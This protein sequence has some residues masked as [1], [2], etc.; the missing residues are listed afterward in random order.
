MP[1]KILYESAIHQ[2]L[3]SAKRLR[4]RL[5]SNF[6]IYADRLASW[7]ARLNFAY[8]RSGALDISWNKPKFG[9]HTL[10]LKGAK[11]YTRGDTV[12]HTQRQA[13]AGM[14]FSDDQ[15]MNSNQTF[16]DAELRA[17]LNSS[18]LFNSSELDLIFGEKCISQYPIHDRK[19]AEES[20][21]NDWAAS[22]DI[23]QI[24]V[25]QRNEACTAPEMRYIRSVLADLKGRDVLDVG[26]GLGEA[27][28]YFALEGASVTA[29]DISSGMCD[30]VRCLADANSVTI[31]T[32]VSAIEDLG[33][34]T[35]DCFDIIY[36]GNT[37][38]HADIGA[39]LANV[40]P[41]L[42]S[43]GIFV[44]WDPI[45]YNPLIQIYRRLASGVRTVD[46]HPLTVTDIKLIKK[47]FEQIEIKFFW[48]FTQAIFVY[49]F[50]LQFRHPGKERFWKKVIDEAEQW[51]TLYHLL[52]KV[53]NF[54]LRW[55]PFL[56]WLCWNVV[57]IAH[58]PRAIKSEY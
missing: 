52:E 55:F 49:M 50:V 38:H 26:C 42:K 3:W 46:E 25:R 31:K 53:D 22:E 19:R 24:N 56:G 21:H 28:V 45:L 41:H 37:L 30:A 23:S 1:K 11:F 2:F 35:K 7:I 29:T 27:S 9:T 51:S 10:I 39:M 32:H 33:L 12:A 47:H 34:S 57:I 14:A 8:S 40:L 20:F 58:R 48:L 13:T 5:Q 54:I 17:M 4:L 18:A 36:T 15:I 44:S 6:P 16:F 43:D